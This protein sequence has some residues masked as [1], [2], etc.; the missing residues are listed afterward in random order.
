MEQLSR[1]DY[2]CR[3]KNTQIAKAARVLAGMGHEQLLM[4]IS[5]A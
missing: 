5:A 4:L 3:M 1:V 2:L